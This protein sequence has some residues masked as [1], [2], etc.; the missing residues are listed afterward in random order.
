MTVEH[1]EA[2]GQFRIA[3]GDEAAVLSYAEAGDGVVDFQRTWV[4]PSHRHQ[5]IGERLVRHALAW[6]ASNEYR[7]IPSC[8]FVRQVVDAGT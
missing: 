3:L 4:P 2:S 7:V 5:G 1:D 8:W 6:A